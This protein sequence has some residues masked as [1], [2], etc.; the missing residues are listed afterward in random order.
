M[1][2]RFTHQLGI[3][4]LNCSRDILSFARL[5]SAKS[6]LWTQHLRLNF[7]LAPNLKTCFLKLFCFAAINNMDALDKHVQKI[8]KKSFR[9]K[10]VEFDFLHLSLSL[11]RM[12]VTYL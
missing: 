12:Y 5:S 4:N 7:V 8:K 3:L 11:Y 6:R 2:P 9:C 10:F 1:T